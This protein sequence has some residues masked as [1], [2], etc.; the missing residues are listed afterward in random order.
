MKQTSARQLAEEL[1]GQ[2]CVLKMVHGRCVI[3]I[4]TRTE[5]H[6]YGGTWSKAFKTLF[7]NWEKFRHMYVENATGSSTRKPDEASV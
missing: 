2:P 3:F 1:T 5:T 6:F 7:H 4:G